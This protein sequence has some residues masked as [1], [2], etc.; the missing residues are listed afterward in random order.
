MPRH[1][2]VNVAANMHV[3]ALGSECRG[4]EPTDNMHAAILG[5]ISFACRGIE[6]ITC[7]LRALLPF[8][9]SFFLL[10]FYSYCLKTI[11]RSPNTQQ[12]ASISITTTNKK[13]IT[14]SLFFFFFFLLFFSFP[15][16]YF[17]SHFLLPLSDL[18]F[19]QKCQPFSSL[20]LGIL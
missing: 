15:L 9:F 14:L 6:L 19:S 17:F 1:W 11:S 10:L 3:A 18:L 16:L 8:F 5:W 7:L 2:E 4:I 12:K 13:K 20:C